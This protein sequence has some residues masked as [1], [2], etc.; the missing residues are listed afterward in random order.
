MLRGLLVVL[1][2]GTLAACATVPPA[3]SGVNYQTFRY[4]CCQG[5]ETQNAW[6][7]GERYTL[8]WTAVPSGTTSV[9]AARP[10]VLRTRLTGPF[11]T[12]TDLK[13]TLASG[14]S[15]GGTRSVDGIPLQ[16]D[17]RTESGV[18]SVIQL[19]ADLP[20]GYYN[21][22]LTTDFGGGNRAGGGAI[23]VVN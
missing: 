22:D 18:T 21:L 1:I 23:I 4:S 2:A 5:G 20:P 13:N 6:H 10:I 19:P 11:A 12:A 9:A 15:T 7:P 8:Q 17:D 14:A 3:T 16:I